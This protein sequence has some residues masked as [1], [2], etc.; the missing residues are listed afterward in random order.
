M[1]ARLAGAALAA[2][3]VLVATPADARRKLPA[4][5]VRPVADAVVDDRYPHLREPEAHATARVWRLGVPARFIPGRLKCAENVN[6][7]LAARGIRGSG[8]AMAKSFLQWGRASGP[9]PGAVAVY[10]RG[11]PGAATGHVAIVAAVSGGIVRVWNPTPH[12]WRLV[13]QHRRAI[14]YRVPA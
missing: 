14:A 8:S 4:F 7:A 2:L 6:A 13:P 12:G 5:A 1:N 10:H 11:R 3:F 9:V